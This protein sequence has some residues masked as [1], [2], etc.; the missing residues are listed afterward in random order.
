MIDPHSLTAPARRLQHVM[1]A[2][3][4]AILLVACALGLGLLVA[5]HRIGETLA[6]MTGFESGPLAVWQHAALIAA[7]CVHLA[8]WFALIGAARAV[9]RALADGRPEA[10]AEASRALA[11]RLWLLLGW[12]LASQTIVSVVAT[13]GYPVGQRVLQLSLGSPQVSLVLAALIA[14]VMARSFALGA[15]LWR[16]HQAMV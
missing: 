3:L 12:G 9:F 6:T 10:A 7:L 2:G 5:P 8:V 16:D 11:C 4:A 13:W 15:E 14:S 1:S